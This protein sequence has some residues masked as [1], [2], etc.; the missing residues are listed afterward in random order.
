MDAFIGC[1]DVSARVYADQVERVAD[2]F[3][4]GKIEPWIG[5]NALT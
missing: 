5:D 2:A 3:L 4:R 1:G